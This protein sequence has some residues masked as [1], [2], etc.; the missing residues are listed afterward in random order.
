[1]ETSLKPEATLSLLR[2]N[3]VT[4]VVRESV[5]MLILDGTLMPGQHVSEVS[6][7]TRLQ[8]SRGPVREACR[9]LVEAGLLVFH[10][11]R[12]FFVRELTL[13]EVSDVYEVR[14][15]LARLAGRTLASM[16]SATQIEHLRDMVAEMDKAN[17]DRDFEKFYRLNLEFHERIIEF[18]GNRRLLSIHQALTK[19]LHIFRRRGLY[20][21]RN[22]FEANLEHHEI[23]EALVAREAERVGASSERHVLHGKE[24]FL[25]AAGK[26]IRRSEGR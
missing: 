17:E 15:C 19:E 1:M 4:Q 3:S 11:N 13:Q 22:T 23:V 18:T 7:S 20:P 6:F 5:E 16:I 9:A 2:T 10:V 25:A 24:R 21:G 14:G 12:G 26:D 8:V